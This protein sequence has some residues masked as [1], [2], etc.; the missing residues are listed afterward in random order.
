M[1]AEHFSRLHDLV[2]GIVYSPPKPLP[3]PFTGKR[4]L[5]EALLLDAIR[6]FHLLVHA[7]KPGDRQ[8]FAEVEA[9]ITS[10]D[11]DYVFSFI[12]VCTFL[13][14]NADA[15]RTHLSAWQASQ[16]GA[17]ARLLSAPKSRARIV[18]R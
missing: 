12:N 7:R 13:G 14:L 17:P 16:N 1:K 3:A 9:W 10:A 5:L 11:T 18:Q 6:T 2:G 8:R 15:V 4:Q